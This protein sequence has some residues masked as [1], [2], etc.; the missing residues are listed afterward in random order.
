MNFKK[1]G[2]RFSERRKFLLLCFVFYDF[3]YLF[4]RISSGKS[5]VIN[6]M[7]WDKVF[8]SG[9]GYI[10]NCFLSVEGIDGDRVY[11]M[12]EGLEEKKSVKV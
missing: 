5:F 4:F 7:L 11:F 3:V 9:I 10:I 1:V 6:V 12:I 2:F 8:F